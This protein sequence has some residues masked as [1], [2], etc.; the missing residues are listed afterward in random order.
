LTKQQTKLDREEILIGD[1][2]AWAKMND[3]ASKN[4]MAKAGRSARWDRV[5]VTLAQQMKNPAH[6]R[7]LKEQLIPIAVEQ[8]LTYY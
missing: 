1:Q 2:A 4:Q 8:M 3:L 6:Q 7:K 5:K